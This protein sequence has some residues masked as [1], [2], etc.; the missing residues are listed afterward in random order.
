[1]YIL[2]LWFILNFSFCFYLVHKVLE[3]QAEDQIDLFQIDNNK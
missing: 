2:E 3:E 1:M